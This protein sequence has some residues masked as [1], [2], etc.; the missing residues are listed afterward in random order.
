MPDEQ[1]P[2]QPLAE[3]ILA[4]AERR[5]K[6]LLA[7]AEAEAK[8][9]VDKAKQEAQHLI[10]TVVE[11][12][13]E[14][15]RHEAQRILA[16]ITQEAR[17]FDLAARQNA[18]DKV[19]DA[20]LKELT[21]GP[22]QQELVVGMCVRAINGMHGDRFI[23]ALGPND[24][25]NGRQICH[26]VVERFMHE[27]RDVGIQLDD[28]PARILGGAI[29]RTVDGRKVFDN[30]FDERLQRARSELR[31]EIAQVLFSS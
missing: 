10:D 5:A 14:R 12:A 22:T 15:A 21:S 23:V 18:I 31:S 26:T 7:R 25:A 30:S 11:H 4:D 19:F 16:T 8:D 13:Q 27:G 29:V 3:E 17:S 20:A 2:A 28:E 6:R 1:S 9:A 24:H